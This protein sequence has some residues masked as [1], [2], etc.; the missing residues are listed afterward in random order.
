MDAAAETTHKVNTAA[1]Q[2]AKVTAARELQQAVAK[3]GQAGIKE[4]EVFKKARPDLADPQHWAQRLIKWATDADA[5]YLAHDDRL[6][7]EAVRRLEDR[8]EMER[9]RKEEAEKKKAVMLAATRTPNQ[10]TKPSLSVQDQA[11]KDATVRGAPKSLT[12]DDKAPRVHTGG[13]YGA[14]FQAPRPG[15]EKYSPPQPYIATPAKS[16]TTKPAALPYPE[17]WSALRSASDALREDDLSV[18]IIQAE[19]FIKL[20][21]KE[22]QS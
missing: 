13:E 14:K 10:H 5:A 8:R 17:L 19:L 1:F 11:D 15:S 4:I 6:R 12:Q 22:L 21:K 3:A 9:T 18:A 16:T 20:A 2:A 7:A